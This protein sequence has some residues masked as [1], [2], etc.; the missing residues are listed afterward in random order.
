[1]DPTLAM[2]MALIVIPSAIIRG[3]GVVEPWRAVDEGRAFAGHLV[4]L[5]GIKP[6]QLAGVFG[7]PTLEGRFLVSK[8]DI[9]RRRGW[10]GVL[11]SEAWLDALAVV[12]A[13]S[14]LVFPNSL[15]SSAVLIAFAHQVLGWGA[16]FV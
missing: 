6:D 9:R 7:P 15:T 5:T 11:L 14:A 10:R 13:I 8:A 3:M 4:L 1:M 16:T 2:L 12:I